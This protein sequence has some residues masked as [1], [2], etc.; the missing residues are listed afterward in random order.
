MNFKLKRFF[1]AV[2]ICLV[3]SL[4]IPA[5]AQS[6]QAGQQEVISGGNSLEDSNENSND[7]I[8]LEIYAKS[9]NIKSGDKAWISAIAKD[10]LGNTIAN[11]TVYFFSSLELSGVNVDRYIGEAQTNE[12]GI[13][14]FRP[15]LS[16]NGDYG[17]ILIGCAA[18]NE[19][20]GDAYYSA[21]TMITVTNPYPCI[22]EESEED[23]NQN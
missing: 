13:A 7:E 4:C 17:T 6:A 22:S 11:Q 5:S 2:F 10:N 19:N 9:K 15:A 20:T 18:E 23:D 21:H 16:V 14:I 1:T 3:I 8:F 12:K